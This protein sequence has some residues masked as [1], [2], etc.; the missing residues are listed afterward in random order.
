MKSVFTAARA[1]LAALILGLS[2]AAPLGLSPAAFAQERTEPQRSPTSVNPTA[3]SVKETDLLNALGRLDGR[4]SIPNPEARLLEQPQGRTWRGF[5]EG[6]IP[7]V[8]AI[9]ILGMVA[10]LGAFFLYRGRIRVHSGFSGQKVTRFPFFDRLVHWVGSFTFLILALTGVNYI[11][12]KRLLLPIIGDAAFYT[13]S[14]NAKLVHHYLAYPFMLSVLLMFVLWVRD[15]VPNRLDLEWIRQGGGMFK[16]QHV[17][18]AR[19]NFGQK[20]I[21]WSVVLGGLALSVTGVALQFRFDAVGGVNGFQI[22]QGLHSLIALLMIAIIIAHIYIGSLGME[23][24][25]SA[26]GSGHVDLNWAKEHHSI[27]LEQ[28]GARNSQGPQA[29]TRDGGRQLQ[30]AE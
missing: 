27:W 5:H 16:G 23:G 17:P 13:W 1:G 9:A 14:Q 15:N 7:Y 30:P 18:A 4:V 29:P 25:F 21:F 10:L 6:I 19:F 8:G 20:M 28:Q 22:A 3:Q 2:A 11:F 24:A 12:G 26:M